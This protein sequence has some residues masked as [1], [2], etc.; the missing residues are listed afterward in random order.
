MAA[1]LHPN[2][3]GFIQIELIFLLIRGSWSSLDHF[4]TKMSPQKN[5]RSATSSPT[6]SS[7]MAKRVKADGDRD[8]EVRGQPAVDVNK[9]ETNLAKRI[10]LGDFQL[11]SAGSP[12]SW[13][14]NFF[15][16]FERRL[17]HRLETLL[18]KRLDDLT[19]QVEEHNEKMKSIDFDVC[20][21]QKE[22]DKLKKMNEDLLIKC[23]DL[24]NRSRRN[25]LVLFGIKEVEAGF[26]DCKK[27]VQD[28][29]NFVG[30]PQDCAQA[31]Q[32]CHRTPTH[33]GNVSQ[34][35]PRMI[36]CSFT[37]FDAKE[38]IRKVSIQKLKSTQ[39]QYHGKRV[40]VGE[41]LSKRI[42]ALRRSKMAAFKKLQVE[43]KKPFFAWPDKIRYR[44]QTTG[45]IVT[46]E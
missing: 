20:A 26:E 7:P 44:D 35:K 8:T 25:N 24:E 16:D 29:L 45:N 28:F 41:D 36:H 34:D 1:G 15:A 4:V 22:V 6:K 46:V 18:V 17:D 40:F 14:V 3:S 27:T 5:S 13:F 43:G 12:P 33:R 11:E 2:S 42:Q 39:S 30:A 19:A 23:D 31:L 32:R 10:L 38:T 37:S 21:V 9:P